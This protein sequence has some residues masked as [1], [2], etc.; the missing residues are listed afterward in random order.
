[1]IHGT[2]VTTRLSLEQV[3]AWKISGVTLKQLHL[4]ALTQVNR[5]TAGWH[6]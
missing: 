4:L 2:N 6:C 5:K 3:M 1:M